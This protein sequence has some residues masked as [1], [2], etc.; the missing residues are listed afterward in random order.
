MNMEG[1]G[2]EW[3]DWESGRFMKGGEGNRGDG[4][5]GMST[6]RAIDK[7]YWTRYCT[8]HGILFFIFL[9]SYL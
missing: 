2:R 6:G 4:L 5:E 8:V 3:G 1:L 9:L 7:D